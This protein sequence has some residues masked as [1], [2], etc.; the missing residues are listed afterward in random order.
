MIQVL[1]SFWVIVFK[2]MQSALVGYV[3]LPDYEGHWL[4]LKEDQIRLRLAQCLSEHIEE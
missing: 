2:F 1:N 3:P 4:H